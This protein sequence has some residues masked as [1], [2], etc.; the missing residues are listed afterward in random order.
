VPT[1]VLEGGRDFHIE[2]VVV[3]VI[4]HCR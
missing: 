3:G 4:R 2:G 1:L